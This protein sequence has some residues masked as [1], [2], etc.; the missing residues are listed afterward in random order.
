MRIGAN[1]TLRVI[2]WVVAYALALHTI[3]LSFALPMVHAGASGELQILC[4]STDTGGD[5]SAPQSHDVHCPD[6]TAAIGGAPPPPPVI[7]HIERIAHSH[8][9]SAVI[10]ERQYAAAPYRPGQPRAPPFV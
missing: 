5:K 7:A 2:G 1:R 8:A 3:L 4:L 10:A 6:C 9:V